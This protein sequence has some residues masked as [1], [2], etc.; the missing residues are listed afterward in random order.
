MSKC[1]NFAIP[2]PVGKIKLFVKKPLKP[3]YVCIFLFELK[4]QWYGVS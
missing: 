1:Q 3:K 2:I 4:C